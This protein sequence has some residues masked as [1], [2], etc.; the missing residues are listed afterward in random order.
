MVRPRFKSDKRL[1][2][3]RD[4]WSEECDRQVAV[5]LAEARTQP[6]P[7][8]RLRI[9]TGLLKSVD[10]LRALKRLTILELRESGLTWR[11]IG[12]IYGV[13]QQTARDALVRTRPFPHPEKPVDI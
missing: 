10:E 12:A 6:N 2:T 3:W 4:N 8:K 5:A 11:A 7:A 13:S 9:T 1:P